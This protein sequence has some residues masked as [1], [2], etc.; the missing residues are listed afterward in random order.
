MVVLG[1]TCFASNSLFRSSAAQWAAGQNTSHHRIV[2]ETG[3]SSAQLSEY[4]SQ[5]WLS[6]HSRS[7]DRAVPY[8]LCYLCFV[9]ITL[10]TPPH[11]FSLFSARRNQSL[12]AHFIF[13]RFLL[14][15]SSSCL[16]ND[17]VLSSLDQNFLF[18]LS[19]LCTLM[20]KP[21]TKRHFGRCSRRW[22]DNIRIGINEIQVKGV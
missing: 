1:T 10:F 4:V 8:F 3:H 5:F 6:G 9:L 17:V 21:R 15:S 18:S 16:P 13:S 11:P 22:Q 14:S 12:T 19:L 7:A 20:G 2:V